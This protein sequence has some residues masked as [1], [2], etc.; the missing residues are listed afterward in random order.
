[1]GK[2][3]AGG[4]HVINDDRN[5]AA[6]TSSCFVQADNM[7]EPKLARC[8]DRHLTACDLAEQRLEPLCPLKAAGIRRNY[9][10]ILLVHVEAGN[11]MLDESQ[12]S[13]EMRRRHSEGVFKSRGIMHVSGHD[14]VYSD[15]LEQLRDIAQRERVRRHVAPVSARLAE[16][17]DNGG[18][19]SG[20]G[21]LQRTN[22]EQHVAQFVARAGP[23]LAVQC[24]NDKDLSAAHVDERLQFALA[25][26]KLG[27][28]VIAQ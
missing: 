26:G 11:E 5:P 22:K 4:N 9:R 10:E 17:R 8:R 20:G 25:I 23:W 16:V 13:F 27:F 21:I 15:G 1:M 24:G 28:D 7:I 2:R 6:N 14:A 19:R 3:R 18:D 12:S